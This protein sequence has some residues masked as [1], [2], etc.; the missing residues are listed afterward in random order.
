MT[1]TERA[2]DPARDYPVGDRR[3]ELVRTPTGRPLHDVTVAAVV[4]GE[5]TLDDLRITPESLGRQA[6]VAVAS[7]RPALAANF[8]RAAELTRIPDD[9][10]LAIYDALRPRRSTRAQ[11]EAIAVELETA[12]DAPLNA[13]LIREA[14]DAY[15]ARD[16]FASN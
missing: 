4:A 3:P 13:A 16:L 12:Y 15:A 8:A 10:I 9:R 7:G 5:F 14:A 2:F 1:G 11:L 6:E